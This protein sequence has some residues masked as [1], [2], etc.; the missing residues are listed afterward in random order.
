MFYPSHCSLLDLGV[1]SAE[2]DRLVAENPLLRVRQSDSLSGRAALPHHPWRVE[3][4]FGE[5]A[6]FQAAAAT[7]DRLETDWQ[8]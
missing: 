6:L 2:A 3:I 7:A 5:V 4:P 8:E 1:D